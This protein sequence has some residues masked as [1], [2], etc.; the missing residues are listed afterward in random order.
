MFTIRDH[1]SDQARSCPT[2]HIGHAAIQLEAL[3]VIN[4]DG[5]LFKM[6]SIWLANEQMSKS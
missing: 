5:S 4:D 1:N 6:R 2:K 3:G